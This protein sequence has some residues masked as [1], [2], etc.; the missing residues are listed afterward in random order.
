[1]LRRRKGAKRLLKRKKPR[2]VRVCL[3]SVHVACLQAVRLLL[4]DDALA[5][6]RLLLAGVWPLPRCHKKKLSRDH[7]KTAFCK[8]YA[9]LRLLSGNIRNYSTGHEKG[10]SPGW[11]DVSA[12]TPFG[13]L[14]TKTFYILILYCSCVTHKRTIDVYWVSTHLKWRFYIGA[15]AQT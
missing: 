8:T 7:G 13:Q 10:V 12:G 4:Y 5:R 15:R 1:M 3:R 14:N 6:R 2:K 11:K 9:S